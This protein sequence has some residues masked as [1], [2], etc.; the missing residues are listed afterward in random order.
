VDQ[1]EETAEKAADDP[2][3]SRASG[4]ASTA[5]GKQA[6]LSR[7]Q[8]AAAHQPATRT[9]EIIILMSLAAV[10]FITIVDFMVIMPL[11][12]QL[13]RSLSIG[14]REFGLVVSSYTLAGGVAGLVASA[15]IDRLDRKVAFLTVDF[16]FLVGTLL[17]GLAPTYF[18]LVLARLAT[19]AFGGILGGMA[20]AI[21]GDVFPEE[22][23][24]RATGA[25]MSGFALASVLGVPLGLVLGNKHGW[26]VPFLAL[27]VIGFPILVIA[28]FALPRM[29]GHLKPG[30]MREHPFRVMVDTFLLP[31]HLNAFALVVSL[32]FAGFIVFPYVSPYL[33]SNVGLSEE[34]LPVVFIAGGAVTLFSA[35]LI[36]W[37]AD[38]FGKLRVFRIVAPT[39]AIMTLAVTTLGPSPAWIPIAL[40]AGLMVSNS[41][42]MVAAMAM[43]TSSVAPNRRGGFLSA[44]SCVQHLALG[45]GA[46]IGGLIVVARED[47]SLANFSIVGFLSAGATILSLWLAGRIRPITPEKELTTTQALAAGAEGMYDADEPVM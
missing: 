29:S 8:A 36:G 41:G 20:M 2:A 37:L 27:A 11:G 16:G 33:I 3:P 46:Y 26:Q 40:M 32:M 10:Q 44:N 14:T 6:P 23:R 35:P 34:L 15:L 19:G 1:A 21:I 24:G 31:A 17:C 38:R 28:L 4:I 45:V 42:R 22:R 43:I 9:R 39:S 12:P 47:N 7:E 5:N 30:A 25:L 18:T 13:M